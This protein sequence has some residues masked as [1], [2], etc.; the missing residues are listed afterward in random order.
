MT[1]KKVAYICYTKAE[2]R[3]RSTY[4][5]DFNET[6]KVAVI[7]RQWDP[8]TK[9]WV[10]DINESGKALKI[11]QRF[12]NT[13]IEENKPPKK[14]KKRRN[15]PSR[16]KPTFAGIASASDQEIDAGLEAWIDGA[17]EP[18]NPGGTTSYGLV[19]KRKHKTVLRQ[20]RVVGNGKKM[21]S[22]VAEYCGLIALLEWCKANA[23]SE[24]VNVYSDSELLVKQMRHIWRAKKG[25]YYPYY[26][27]A[28]AILKELGQKQFRFMWIPREDNTEADELSKQ[29]IKDVVME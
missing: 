19:V 4:D 5:P 21:S 23:I 29:A 16:V 7:S 11:I 15:Q 22:N 28:V 20:A 25:L 24:V 10:I 8:K 26:Q 6:L 12:Y 3:I 9:E 27:Q 14:P 17:C 13:I 1:V 18:F 2:M